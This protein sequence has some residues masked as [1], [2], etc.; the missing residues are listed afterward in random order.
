MGGLA[1]A[2]LAS[3]PLALALMLA[4][5][6]SLA[7]QG[8][9]DAAPGTP[10]IADA[11]VNG[12]PEGNVKFF[13]DA[14][15]KAAIPLPALRPI[16]GGIVKREILDAFAKSG[17]YVTAEDLE[18]R[19]ILLV[20]DSAALSLRF[21]VATRAME[22][23]DLG[24]SGVVKR[25]AQGALFAPEAFS[26]MLGA[27]AKIAPS[28]AFGSESGPSFAA[29]LSLDP[30]LRLYDVVAQGGFDIAYP[31]SPLIGIR[32]ARLTY[33]LPGL[34]VRTALGTIDPRT[35]SFQVPTALLG[36]GF[37][38]ETSLPGGKTRHPSIIDD[39]QLERPAE[40]TVEINGT[41]VRHLHLLPGSYRLSELPF[42]TGR[43][44]VTLR[45]VEEGSAPKVI[46]LGLP[47]D[48]AILPEGQMD[49]AFNIGVDRETL[50]RP[51]GFA[52]FSIGTTPYLELGLDASASLD[53]FLG[54]ASLLWASPIGSLEAAGAV[55]SAFA[56]PAATAAG[57]AGRIDWRLALPGYR[58]LPRLGAGVEYRSLTFA[59]PGGSAAAAVVEAENASEDII[60]SAQLSQLLPGRL[61]AI[62]AFGT[63]GFS[64]GALTGI[65]VSGGIF[66]SLSR[67]VSISASGGTDWSIDRGL[68]PRAS[69]SLSIVTKSRQNYAFH[70][71]LV[72]WADSFDVSLPLD[73][74]NQY[75]LAANGQ[76]L[77]HSEDG[78]R[79]ANVSA[80]YLGD[81]VDLSASGSYAAAAGGE[82]SQ[83]GLA[84]AASSVLAYAGGY[85]GLS[86]ILGDAFLFLV[87]DS[88]LGKDSVE[89]LP[90]SGPSYSS[91]GGKPLLVPALVPYDA[92]AAT[93]QMPGSAPDR[94][95]L[96]ENLS[97]AP[98]YKSGTVVKIK[99]APNLA[100]RGRLVDAKGGVLA[101]R[102]GKI[103]LASAAK[104]SVGSTF[105][106]ETG[107][108]ECYGLA[109]GDYLVEWGDGGVSRF[110]VAGEGKAMI[111]LGDVKAAP[112]AEGVRK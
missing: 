44:S 88:S 41:V 102:G 95:P 82:G 43:N 5:A 90:D 38:S 99:A 89:I 91:V 85:F 105:S 55:S 17:H 109:A 30:T 1:R 26:A 67:S 97:V 39:L 70:E 29:E 8:N 12:V 110:S 63:A 87:P 56:Y 51:L 24:A 22:P 62:G 31:A 35:V 53:A 80:S 36:L 49:Y 47:F 33:D 21:T 45:I 11:F 78:A 74:K 65:S 13:V 108:F 27:S 9:F 15:G 92:I 73:K 71:D 18:P 6:L 112:A 57:L 42:D 107:L 61:G 84:F 83:A 93:V 98:T 40:L 104:L 59:A 48:G 2:R 94:R 66:I 46:E 103:F 100:V 28:Y 32:E 37:S 10:A 54:G 19:G 77:I 58:Y 60:L 14:G 4:Q 20:Y 50:L 16:L 72:N 64:G 69:I 79:S 106:D 111:E 25:P 101:G 34:G 52:E 7:A 86:P 23:R 76:G 96:P 68:E 3:L 75:T 81:A